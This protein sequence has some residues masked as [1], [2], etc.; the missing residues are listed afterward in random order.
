MGLVNSILSR[1]NL[2]MEIWVVDKSLGIDDFIGKLASNNYGNFQ[3][4]T[5]DNFGLQRITKSVLKMINGKMT[6]DEE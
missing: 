2:I 6:L 1:V 5:V 4:V 3:L